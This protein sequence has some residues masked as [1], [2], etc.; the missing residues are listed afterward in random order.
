M[1]LADPSVLPFSDARLGLVRGLS[2]RAR[3]QGFASRPTD[4][5][6]RS[7]TAP[8]TRA[9]DCSR[10]TEVE[11]T[12]TSTTCRRASSA[13]CR[14]N[15]TSTP[16]PCAASRVRVV[17]SWAEA[18]WP[19]HGPGF[20]LTGDAAGMHQPLQRRGHR[21]RLRDRPDRG[22]AHRRGAAERILAE[23]GRIHRRAEGNLRPLLSAR[24]AF[25]EADR[26]PVAH[27]EAG[28]HWD[29]SARPS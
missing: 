20:L 29:E 1:G 16:T 15:G 8:S 2:R 19:P 23:P 25:R 11:A 6:F 4:G 26:L 7:V 9:S 10:P 5:C 3:R 28:I 18:F 12:S 13:S 14:R 22:T 17:C 24:P 21:L 27:G